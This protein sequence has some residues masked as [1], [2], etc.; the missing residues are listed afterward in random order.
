MK[1]AS[2]TISM[3]SEHRLSEY[4]SVEHLEVMTRNGDKAMNSIAAYAESKEGSMV[5]GMREFNRQEKLTEEQQRKENEQNNFRHLLERMNESRN[6]PV[7]RIN[8]ETDTQIKLLRR[9]LAALSG[10]GRFE[11][12][13]LENMKK[14][15]ALDLRSSAFKKADMVMQIRGAQGGAQAGSGNLASGLTALDVGTS[16][17]GTVWQKISATSGIHNESEYTTFKSTGLAVTE[18]G[19]SISFG[20]ELSMSRSF[21]AKFE[22]LTSEN[23]IVTDPLIINLDNGYAGLTDVKFKFDL[24][25]DGKMDEI[26]FAGEGS[27]FLALDKDGN[28]KID[29]GSELFG[30]KSGDGFAD[31]AAYDDDGNS[32]IDENDEIYSKLKVWTKDADGNDKLMNLK[33]ANVGAIYLGNASTEFSI[34]DDSNKMQGAIRKTGLYLKETGEVGTIQHVDLAM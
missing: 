4:S 34:K 12:F 13:E 10:K 20:M 26:S 5:A 16:V 14:G 23:I 25:S 22:S 3:N 31:L 18:D 33:E 29:D 2:S 6:Q 28:G 21:T 7:F 1:I 11:P 17:S 8:D 24:D 32:W 9:L 30:T 15:E 19:R 27:G